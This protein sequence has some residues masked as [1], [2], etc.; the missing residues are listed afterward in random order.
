[1]VASE[2]P[3]MP[4]LAGPLSL[5]RVG[6]ESQNLSASPGSA[7]MSRRRST[8]WQRKGLKRRF[9][10]HRPAPMNLTV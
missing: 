4:A 5:Q 2:L 3:F 1:M 10:V 7:I 6:E 8:P 9:D